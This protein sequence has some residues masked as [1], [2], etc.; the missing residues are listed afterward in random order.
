MFQ[1]FNLQTV[2][3]CQQRP[4]WATL[5]IG[6]NV[7]TYLQYCNIDTHAVM[8]SYINL[9]GLLAPSMKHVCILYDVYFSNACTAFIYHKFDNHFFLQLLLHVSFTYVM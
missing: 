7:D 1:I 4:R 8:D 6:Q 2:G 9:E 3:T 5:P